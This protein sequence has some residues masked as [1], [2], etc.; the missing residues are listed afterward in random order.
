MQLFSKKIK[1]GLA[2]LFELAKNYN[3]GFLQIK[4]IS[5]NQKIPQNYLEQLLSSLRKAEL[6]ESLRGAQGGYRLKKPA[7][8]IKIIDIIEAL[9]GPLTLVGNSKSNDFFEIYWGK[10]ETNFK[11]ILSDTLEDLVE[12]E[13]TLHKR[14]F[15]EI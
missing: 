2:A 14:L 5:V 7:N 10:I 6:V 3:K 9:D 13:N 11:E 8:T 4:E 1:Y 15:Y 12:E